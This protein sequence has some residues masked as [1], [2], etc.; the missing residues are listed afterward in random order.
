M[1]SILL[2]KI[3]KNNMNGWVGGGGWMGEEIYCG[4]KNE[5][6]EISECVE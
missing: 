4:G 1:G 6:T 3:D 5:T 2:V